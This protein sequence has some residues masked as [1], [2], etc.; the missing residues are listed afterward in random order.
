MSILFIVL[1][2]YGIAVHVVLYPHVTETLAVIESVLYRPY[3]QIYGE[4]FLEE[5]R[6]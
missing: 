1:V 3:F 4:L 5:V 6:G 2:G